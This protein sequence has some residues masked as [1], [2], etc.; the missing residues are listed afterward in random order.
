MFFDSFQYLN[1]LPGDELINMDSLLAVDPLLTGVDEPHSSSFKETVYPNPALD[2][3]N[4]SFV[5]K[6]KGPYFIRFYAIDGQLI[7]ELKLIN[8]TLEVQDVVWN[9][10]AY[11]K[12]GVYLYEINNSEQSSKGKFIVR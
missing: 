2:N 5:N 11:V 3:L 1:Y 6:K 4:I 8:S 7:D 9:I 10:P 12:A